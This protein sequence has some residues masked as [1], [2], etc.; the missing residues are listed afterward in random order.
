M[1][2]VFS[3]AAGER[4]KEGKAR[5]ELRRQQQRVEHVEKFSGL[6]VKNRLVASAVLEDKFCDLRF[7]R[8][9]DLR[10]DLHGRWATA[11]VLVEKTVK[12]GSTGSSYSVW[13][14]SD[15]SPTDYT[16]SVFLFGQ[17]HLDFSKED[18][19]SVWCVVDGELREDTGQKSHQA[20]GR[21]WR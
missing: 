10:H 5:D 3:T 11:G 13:R 4:A 17:A 2:G 12:Q 6:R 21:L 7:T 19:G 14:L 8:I 1:S 20:T 18:P 9:P 16:V 15:M